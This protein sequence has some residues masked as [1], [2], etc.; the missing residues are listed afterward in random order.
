MV[1]M[2]DNQDVRAALGRLWKPFAD[3]NVITEPMEKN[4][5]S[6]K[7]VS[8]RSRTGNARLKVMVQG[9]TDA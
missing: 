6:A 5:V 7:M 2:N 1:Y 9:V 3:S 4:M 8:K